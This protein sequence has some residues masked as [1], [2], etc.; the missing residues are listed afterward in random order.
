MAQAGHSNHLQ[1]TLHPCA[2]DVHLTFCFP[3]PMGKA[4]LDSD[5]DLRQPFMGPGKISFSL[6]GT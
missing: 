2:V 4:F 5:S 1:V 3:E 6:S